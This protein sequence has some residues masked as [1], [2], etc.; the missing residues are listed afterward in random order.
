MKHPL[1]A[2]GVERVVANA[3]SALLAIHAPLDSN[4]AFLAMRSTSN[5]RSS[6]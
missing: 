6:S 4:S 2:S 3:F 1:I 5:R